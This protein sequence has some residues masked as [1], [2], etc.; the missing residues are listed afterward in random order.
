[1]KVRDLIK[2]LK[3][4]DLNSEVRLI[5]GGYGND[6]TKNIYVSFDD[7]GDVLL[8]EVVDDEI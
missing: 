6:Y 8:Y 4:T 1:M 2:K 5:A 7:L 3:Q